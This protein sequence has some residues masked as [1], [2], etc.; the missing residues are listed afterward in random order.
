MDDIRIVQIE[1]GGFLV[2]I[3]IPDLPYK[4]YYF[5]TVNQL[6]RAIKEFYSPKE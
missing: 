2:T 5:K 1:D 4:Q 6:T 3:T